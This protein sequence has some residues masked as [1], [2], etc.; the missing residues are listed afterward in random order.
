MPSQMHPIPLR[1][2][3]PLEDYRRYPGCRVLLSC[4]AC[5]Y[6]KD[7]NP[8]RIVMRLRELRVGGWKTP[9]VGIAAQMRRPCPACRKMQWTTRLAYPADMTEAE[10]RRLMARMRN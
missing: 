2:T 1:S 10:A 9:I 7:Y 3:D 6:A 5:G 4:G 8:E